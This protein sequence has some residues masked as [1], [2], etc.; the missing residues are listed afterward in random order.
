MTTA[1]STTTR[2][3]AAGELRDLAYRVRRLPDPLRASPERIYAEKDDIASELMSL[4]RRM[5]RA[6]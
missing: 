5:E 2:A 4:A 1:V 3:T 6:A